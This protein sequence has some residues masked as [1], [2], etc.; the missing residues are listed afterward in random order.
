MNKLLIISLIIITSLLL[1]ALF[2]ICPPS[3]PW[4][5]PPWCSVRVES[6]SDEGGVVNN[7]D[8]Q[9]TSN[10]IIH[11]LPSNI[12]IYGRINFESIND[13]PLS[14]TILAWGKGIPSSNYNNFDWMHSEQLKGAK[15]YSTI[16]LW[17][18]DEWV[19]ISDLPKNLTTCYHTGINGE[20]LSIQGKVFLN[21]LCPA[22]R[23]R[24]K[25]EMKSHINAGTNG[26]VFDEVMGPAILV[27]NG[28]GPFDNYSIIG[29]RD[30]LRSKYNNSELISLGVNNVSEF[31][32]S[33]YIING[34]YLSNY[35][36]FWSNP[37]PLQWDYYDYLLS[38]T[39][40]FINELIS[41]AKSINN[42]LVFGA[43]ANPLY[44]N[45]LTSFYDKLDLFIYEHEWFPNWRSNYYNFSSGVPSTP[46]IKYANNIN[47]RAV[48]MP[49]L[50]D[51]DGFTTTQRQELFNHQ[52]AEVYASGGYYTYLPDITYDNVDYVTPRQT[53]YPYY[54]FVRNHPYLFNGTTYT[55]IAVLRPETSFTPLSSDADAVNGYSIIL[56]LN[57]IPHDVINM[58]EINNYELVITSGFNWANN[59][60]NKLFSFVRNGG[61]VIAS[62][63]RFAKWDENNNTLINDLLTTVKSGG[64]TSIGDGLFIFY[65][66]YSWWD[67]WSR[68]DNQ[69]ITR[70]L[71]VVKRYQQ[72]SIAPSNVTILPYINGDS[73]II[74]LINNEFN[75]VFINKTNFVVKVVLPQD[76]DISGKEL[77]LLSPDFN[78]T[79]LDYNVS[80]NYLITTIPSLHLW[81]VLLVK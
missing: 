27:V 40:N 6:V 69:S 26:F 64:A 52:L 23:E 46:S 61:V 43:N 19:T 1:M 41:Y 55:K 36:Q 10:V 17:N 31:N 20:P 74:H 33:D 7:S 9:S 72:P 80:D 68:M 58:S 34:G 15:H 59:S 47:K 73:L 5:T 12:S 35:K 3:G 13:L 18:N 57:N 42:E 67:I 49:S 25:L 78:E 22:L 63:P 39:N 79:I 11:Y 45:K 65:N 50:H 2:R 66:D 24:I 75:G 48:I 53:I 29:F 62:D 32:Y 60:I 8:S 28:E 51:M 54:N 21:I 44:K 30:Y 81:D 77:I 38:E 16:S 76:Y 71:N 56:Y 37:A 4:P 14:I 70:V